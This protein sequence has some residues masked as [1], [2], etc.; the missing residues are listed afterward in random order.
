M[1]T[2]RNIS[3]QVLM[4]VKVN[5]LHC[6]ELL[7]YA[8]VNFTMETNLSLI[9]IDGDCNLCNG[10]AKNIQKR[11]K[12]KLFHYV[13]LQSDSGKHIIKKY[14]ISSEVDSVVFINKKQAFIKS[15]AV[16]EIARLLPFPWSLAV[17]LKFFPKTWRD[18]IYDIVAKKRYK[19]FG[20]TEKCQ[21]HS[22]K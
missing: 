14:N 15:D 12:N 19:W 7:L 3:S 1:L 6:P 5:I 22:F 2:F 9:I 4:S 18:W 8:F 17:T 10:T 16:I 13:S 20:K 21:I 11:D